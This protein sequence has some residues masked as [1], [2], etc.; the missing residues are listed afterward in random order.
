MDVDRCHPL[1]EKTT[2]FIKGPF[3]TGVDFARKR[4]IMETPSDMHF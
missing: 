3:L 1:D 2:E 4:P